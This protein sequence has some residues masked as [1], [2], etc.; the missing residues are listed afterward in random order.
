LTTRIECS[1]TLPATASRS[2]PSPKE[3][4]GITFRVSPTQPQVIAGKRASYWGS[5]VFSLRHHTE[6]PKQASVVRYRLGRTP[7]DFRHRRTLTAFF[8]DAN[9]HDQ[10]VKEQNKPTAMV[11]PPHE[12]RQRHSDRLMTCSGITAMDRGSIRHE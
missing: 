6:L 5:N 4:T 7:Q 3:K 12:W 11:S 10:I 2:Q 8:Q 9:Y 1:Q